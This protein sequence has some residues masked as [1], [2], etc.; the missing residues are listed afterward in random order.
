MTGEGGQIS[1]RTDKRKSS[2]VLKKSVPLGDAAKK[3]ETM[4]LV[5]KK[6]K[7]V[8]KKEKSKK[9]RKNTRKKKD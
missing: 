9:E 3:K 6:R 1:T 4:V 7:M 5:K 8:R 2:C